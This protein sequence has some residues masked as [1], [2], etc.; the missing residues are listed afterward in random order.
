M[1]SA[2]KVGGRRL[3]ELAR[4]GIEVERDAAAGDGPPLRRRVDAPIRS[5]SGSR[6]SAPRAPTSARWPPTSGM[7]SAAVAHLRNLRRTAV[8]SFAEAEAHR[9]DAL[10][11]QPAA[12]ALRDLVVD[13]RRRRRPPPRSPREGAPARLLRVQGD[14]PVGRARRGGDAAR[15]LRAARD[16]RRG[17]AG[18]RARRGDVASVRRGG[19]HRRRPVPASSGGQRRSRS[20]PTTACTSATGGIAEVRR[21]AAELDARSAVV[22]FDRH[23]AAVVRPGV[24]APCC[25]PTSTRSSSCSAATGVDYTV[26][27]HFDE[28]APQG[29]GRGL[30]RGGAGRLPATRGRR[31][32]RGLPLR[33]PAPRQRRAAA[34]DGG[35]ARL[36]VSS[37]LGADRPRTGGREEPVSSTA[38]P[39]GA[40]R[41]RARHRRPHARPA[42]RGAGRRRGRQAGPRARVPDRQR[43]GARGSCL[44]ADGIYA[45]WYERPDGS[46]HP[47]ALS[48]G[49]RPTFYDD[50]PTTRCSRPTC[51]TSTATSTAS[52]P[53]CGSW[54]A[55]GRGAV[56]LRRGPRRPDA[57]DVAAA[58]AVLV[59]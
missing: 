6:S 54:P 45:G 35:H 12:V 22:T 58:R 8:G 24:G 51:S 34:R 46:V 48:L 53:R 29:A 18:R 59:A 33:P 2:V 11:L 5:C 49:R 44:P 30:R 7:R 57:V 39:P 31:G 36:R 13:V 14:G 50:Q 4:E 15:R 43:G 38:D 16:G 25:S 3:H 40:G 28:R 27:R 42:P 9:V 56:R 47:A 26:V 23:P 20:G 1:V 17:Q 19:A 41:G 55:P 52:G 37:P 10:V 32:R 21:G